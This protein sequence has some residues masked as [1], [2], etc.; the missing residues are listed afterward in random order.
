MS[1]SLSNIALAVVL[2]STLIVTPGAKAQDEPPTTYIQ[3]DYMKVAPGSDAEY[4][5]VEGS[6]WKPIH[7]ARRGAGTL[8]SWSLYA[9]R[10][11]SGTNAEYNYVTINI[12]SDFDQTE[13][14]FSGEIVQQAHPGASDADFG[15]MM[16]RTGASRDLVRS[17]LWMAHDVLQP[18]SPA[19]YVTVSHMTVPSGGGGAYLELEREIWK[20]IHASSIEA[21][22]R[23]GWGVYSMMFPNG[24]SE[25]YNY[26][27]ANF[28]DEYSDIMAEIPEEVWA[29]SHPDYTDEMWDEALERTGKVRSVYSSELWQLID[30]T[31]SE[32]AGN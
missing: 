14:A 26:G 30:T 9:V 12:Y 27:T 20:P 2:L 18:P 23:S 15:D 17:E 6:I 7:E 25:P 28:F 3:V 1:K 24:T 8:V 22:Y 19:K 32:A 4:I 11:P 5:D 29:A 21:G 16:A 31:D 10:Y 13:N